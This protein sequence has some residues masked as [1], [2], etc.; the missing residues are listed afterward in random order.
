M[1]LVCNQR[2]HLDTC[3]PKNLVSELVK[4]KE[5]VT[6]K[7]KKS[8]LKS[9]TVWASIGAIVTAAGAYA[10][11]DIGLYQFAQAIIYGLI[12]IFMRSG[13]NE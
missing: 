4:C 11:G 12:A 13:I 7:K 2:A 9:K 10:T 5:N 3:G 6:M 1:W 8:L